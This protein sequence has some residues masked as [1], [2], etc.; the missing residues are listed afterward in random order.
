MLP[1]CSKFPNRNVQYDTN[2]QNLW[3]NDDPVVP[4]ERNLQGHPLAGLLWERQFEEALLELG[5]ENVPNWDFR[6]MS[7]IC[8]SSAPCFAPFLG[9]T[10]PTQSEVEQTSSILTCTRTL[11][12]AR[13]EFLG[14]RVKPRRPQS[15]Q[16]HTTAR[17]PQREIWDGRGKKKTRNFGL[18]T[19][20][21]HN[22]A[23]PKPFA[24]PSI[25]EGTRGA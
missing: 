19:L 21:A 10:K 20:R 4:L 14:C 15:R 22:P 24:P 1:I 13:L 25:P 3:E 9:H 23:G 11:K 6:E 8:D 16:E 5:W 7:S 12:C 18:P 17:E 2:G